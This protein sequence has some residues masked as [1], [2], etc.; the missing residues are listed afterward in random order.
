VERGTVGLCSRMGRRFSPPAASSSVSE[1]PRGWSVLRATATAFVAAGSS[2]SDSPRTGND[3]GV[4]TVALGWFILGS[5]EKAVLLPSITADLL[6]IGWVG[7]ACPR[8]RQRCGGLF[9]VVR[10]YGNGT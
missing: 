6:F 1:L 10:R 4:E 8:P 9:V 5:A 3:S 2:Q 7:Y